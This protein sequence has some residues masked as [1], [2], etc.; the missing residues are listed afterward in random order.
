M[1]CCALDSDLLWCCSTILYA[2][3]VATGDIGR[4]WMQKPLYAAAWNVP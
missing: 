4:F 2:N 1:I 3:N